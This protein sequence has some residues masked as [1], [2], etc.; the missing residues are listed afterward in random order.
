MLGKETG[1]EVVVVPK[2]PT[3]MVKI[4]ATLEVEVSETYGKRHET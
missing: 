2:T 4:C 3:G 1:A